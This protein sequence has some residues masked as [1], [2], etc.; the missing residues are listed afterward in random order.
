M[1]KSNGIAPWDA[2][3]VALTPHDANV[4]GRRFRSDPAGTA[5]GRWARGSLFGRRHGVPNLVGNALPKQ[6]AIVADDGPHALLEALR[7]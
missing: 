4:T 3:M 6:A 1:L 5:D 2:M 7:R